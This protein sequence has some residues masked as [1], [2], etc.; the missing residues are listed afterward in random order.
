MTHE[1][2]QK[3]STAAAEPYRPSGRFAYYFALGKLR[4]DPVFTALL[5][6]G[7][8]PDNSSI[9]DLGC[10]QALL[11]SWLMAAEKFSNTG[12][13]P[14][15]WPMAPRLKTF[16]GIEL[17]RNQVQNARMLEQNGRTTILEG[18]ISEMEY[19][20]ADVVLML[21]VLHYIHYT[22]QVRVLAKVRKAISPSG[23]L[24]MRIGDAAAGLPFHVSKTVDQLM[25]L[26]RG[27]GHCH[28]Y[29]RS[30]EEWLTLL[31]DHGFAVE[32][33]PMSQ[34]TPFANLLIVA[35]LDNTPTL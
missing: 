4:G 18:D 23:F 16:V 33:M 22:A 27:Q 15:H 14:K 11:D 35:R 1:L 32:T 28:L 3:L 6:R 24:L 21:D 12:L 5:E 20:K 13:W 2:I 26:A 29:C 9:L 19:G 34:G 8:I 25:I 10:G 30:L 31:N 17:R 7:L